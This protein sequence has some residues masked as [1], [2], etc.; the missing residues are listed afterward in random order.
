MTLAL[1]KVRGPM[2]NSQW[3]ATTGGN[4]TGNQFLREANS[5]AAPNTIEAAEQR[6]MSVQFALWRLVG[7]YTAAGSQSSVM[8]ARV[9]GVSQAS[10]ATTVGAGAGTVLTDLA[11]YILIKSTD[12]LSVLF[13]F[14]TADAGTMNPRAWLIGAVTASF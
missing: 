12:L 1:L 10:T 4:S 7:S 8:T 14:G 2:V 5:A 6:P 11:A 3:A 9:N 13:K